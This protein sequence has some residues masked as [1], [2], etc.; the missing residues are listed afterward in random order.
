MAA[1]STDGGW[2]FDLRSYDNFCSS[3]S[4]S[5][6]SSPPSLSTDA[7]LLKDIDLTSRNDEAQYKPNPWSIAKINAASRPKADMEIGIMTGSLMMEKKLKK[8]KGL[9]VDFLR[10]QAEGAKD[11]KA[12]GLKPGLPLPNIPSSLKQHRIRPHFTHLSPVVTRPSVSSS[13]LST[14]LQVDINPVAEKLAPCP[15]LDDPAALDTLS[16]GIWPNENSNA[17]RTCEPAQPT[18]FT[19]HTTHIPTNTADNQLTLDPVSVTHAALPVATSDPLSRIFSS[20]DFGAHNTRRLMDEALPLVDIK[21]V[22][23]SNSI[24]LEPRTKLAY[25]DIITNN[26]EF[27]SSSS[28]ERKFQSKRSYPAPVVSFSSPPSP[29]SERWPFAS[30]P[31]SVY[32]TQMPTPPTLHPQVAGPRS[33]LDFVQANEVGA[34][35]GKLYRELDYKT[36]SMTPNTLSDLDPRLQSYTH[37]VYQESLET[38][39]PSMYPDLSERRV[40]FVNHSGSVFEDGAENIRYEHEAPRASTPTV[41]HHIVQPPPSPPTSSPHGPI[42]NNRP[43]VTKRRRSSAAPSRSP[44]SRVRYRTP[45]DAY[46]HPVFEKSPDEEW[47][48]LFPKRRQKLPATG[49][50]MVRKSG[51]FRIP[52]LLASGSGEVGSRRLNSDAKPSESSGE[53]TSKRNVHLYRPPPRTAVASTTPH[54]GNRTT[55]GK[56]AYHTTRMASLPSPPTSDVPLHPT[57]IDID[58]DRSD[59]TSVGFDMETVGARYATVR[60]LGKEVRCVSLPVNS[61]LLSIIT[62]VNLHSFIWLLH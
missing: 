9:I 56:A 5:P 20:S 58:N 2:S 10:K 44:P 43:S 8:P 53:G 17:P 12:D 25:S 61:I 60:R 14:D 1:S 38:N 47:S 30:N 15:I 24:A 50:E 19:R 59:G 34:Q 6:A 23:A 40:P 33:R 45:T 37:P 11:T 41:I 36:S 27:V 22:S 16:S 51:K 46:R 21:P 62:L 32:R 29:P 31:S 48:T 3:S 52:L 39:R 18:Y 7:Q 42:Q 4:P 55:R 57:D 13:K 26:S 28:P 35:E 49:K 54:S